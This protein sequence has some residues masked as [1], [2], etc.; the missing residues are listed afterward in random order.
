LSSDNGQDARAAAHF[1]L[2]L[3]LQSQYGAA[4]GDAMLADMQEKLATVPND[5][6]G[7]FLAA[8][9]LPADASRDDLLVQALREHRRVLAVSSVGPTIIDLVEG[10]V[11]FR[12]THDDGKPAVLMVLASERR[13]FFEEVYGTTDFDDRVDAYG[14]AL[15]PIRL[16]GAHFDV[17]TRCIS[18]R[19][20]EFTAALEAFLS[21]A[22]TSATPS[23]GEVAATPSTGEV[24]RE[25]MGSIEAEQ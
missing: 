20:S 14:P 24:V 2:K 8:Q 25:V 13:A 21:S 1:I 17:V 22:W 18:N 5:A 12:S 6:V 9:S 23:T 15:E 4:E 3:R 16:D 19:A 10:L 7:L 11:P